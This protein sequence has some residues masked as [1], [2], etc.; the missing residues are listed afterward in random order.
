MGAV[1]KENQDLKKERRKCSF[2]PLELTFLLDGGREKTRR[3]REIENLFFSDPELED[4]VPLDFLSHK[5]KYEETIR[6]ATYIYRKIKEGG[7]ANKWLQLVSLCFRDGAL[8]SVL[9]TVMKDGN[10]FGLNMVM[11]IPAVLGQGTPEQREKWAMRAIKHN[12]IA[13]YAQTELGHGTFIRGLETTATYDPHTKEFVLNSPTLSSYKWWPGGMGQTANYAVVM[14]QLYTNGV[15]R[16]IHLFVVQLRDEETHKP[17]PG[18]KIGEIGTKVGMHTVNNGFLGFENVR[19]P[20][21]QMLMKNAKVL[22]DG[23]YV[24]APSDKLTY[25]AMTFV[26]VIIVQGAASQIAQAATIA[27]RYSAVRRQSEMKP[28]FTANWLWRLYSEV[29]TELETGQLDRLPEVRSVFQ[30]HALSCCLKAVCT[31][32]AAHSVEVFRLSCG[33]HGYMTCSNFSSI[34]GNATASCTYEGENTVMLLQTA[35]FLMK[36]W[37]QASGG[38]DM[39]PTVAYLQLAIRDG[40]KVNRW[41]NSTQSTILFHRKIKRAADSMAK[42]IKEGKSPEVAWNM[43]SIEL[44]EC[45]EAHANAFL[46]EKFVASVADLNCSQTLKAVLIQL[47]ELYAVFNV[48]RK[49]GDFLMYSNLKAHDI[50]SLQN[51]MEDLLMHIRPNAIGIVDG[52]DFHDRVLDSPL[53]AWDGNVYERLF[54]VASKSPLNKEPSKT[55]LEPPIICSV[56]FT[57]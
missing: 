9:S 36:A 31:A 42:R 53:G 55:T 30:L 37:Q 32:E 8:Y 26:R 28:G 40:N 10:P 2:N 46:V 7:L 34:Y 51:W 16:G 52:F 38:M 4:K 35:R 17:M 45:A 5:E 18:I 43:S 11:F 6:K 1:Q 13:T 21:D 29:T 49:T 54:E 41:E 56:T 3:R 48:L 22:E 12:I 24:K 23:S 39:T 15:H 33:G 47:S 19:I 20:R 50:Q 44:T 25:G 27:I 14:A 57:N